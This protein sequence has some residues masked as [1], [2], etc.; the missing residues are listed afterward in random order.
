[1]GATCQGKLIEHRLK[2]LSFADMLGAQL[3]FILVRARSP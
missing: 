2:M 3:R 1:M